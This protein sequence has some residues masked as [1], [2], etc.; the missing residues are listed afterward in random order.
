MK[1]KDVNTSDLY[2]TDH[3]NLARVVM[4]G[5]LWKHSNFN[6]SDFPFSPAN[7]TYR[8][9]RGGVGYSGYMIGHLVVVC[10]GGNVEVTR[11]HLRD[12]ELP[13]FT[14]DTTQ[15]EQT[16]TL[17]AFKAKLDTGR[18]FRLMVVNTQRMQLQT[19][20]DAKRR[21]ERETWERE[22]TK[23]SVRRDLA[24]EKFNVAA[25]ELAEY[26][27]SESEINI[28][29]HTVGY[30]AYAGD[31]PNVNLTLDQLL[32]ILADAKIGRGFNG[33]VEQVEQLAD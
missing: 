15:T 13:V 19:D 11:N 22:T 31:V 23:K 26:G 3:G 30:K 20:H 29:R 8:Q 10:T 21:A 27:L 7:N 5:Q 18:D 12:M 16:D 32:P 17:K 14:S 6:R 33:F 4:T 25:S 1:L 9:G 24:K 2:I 28:M